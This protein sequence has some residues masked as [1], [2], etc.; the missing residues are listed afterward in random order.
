MQRRFILG[1]AVVLL[2]T[3]T[4]CPPT[5]IALKTVVLS[6][7][8]GVVFSYRE[9]DSNSGPCFNVPTYGTGPE[10]VP[11][12]QIAVGWED[13]FVPGAQPFPCNYQ[14]QM[15]YRG[16]VQF[17]LRRFD[18]IADATLTY[19]AFQSENHTAGPPENPPQGYATVLGMATGQ[20]DYGNGPMWWPYDND[21]A[22]PPCRGNSFT[23]CSV[24]VSY[25]SNQWTQQNHFNYGFIMAGPKLDYDSGLPQDNNAQLTWYGNFQLT[26]LYNP[27][28]N[29]RAPQ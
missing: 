15:L 21:V 17:D 26:V 6:P 13:T 22:L 29:P 3:L 1:S 11:P 16:H 27:A 24:D 4:G 7:S 12:G 2:I 8:P 25:Q 9:H 23:P 14:Q 28:L 19:A 18:S 10:V 5:P 20:A